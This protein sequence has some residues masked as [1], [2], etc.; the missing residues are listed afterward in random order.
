MKYYGIRQKILKAVESH[1]LF[2]RGDTLIIGFSGGADSTALL[3]LLHDL[4]GYELKLIAA[5]L[6]HSLRGK[7]SDLDELF[8][9]QTAQKLG[10][11]FESSCTDVKKRAEERGLNLEDAGRQ[12]RRDFFEKISKKYNANTIVLAQHADDQAE[13]VLMRLL[14]GSGATGLSG[15]EYRNQYGYI[16]PLLDISRKEIVSWLVNEGIPWREDESNNDTAFLRNRIRHELLPLLETYNPNIRQ[17]LLTTA[18]ILAAED[19]LLHSK[20]RLAVDSLFRTS[21]DGMQCNVKELL[22][23]PLPM[24]RRIIRHAY[25]QTAE[26]LHGFGW[27]HLKNCLQ[28]CHSGH[29]N[30]FISLPNNVHFRKTYDH[31]CISQTTTELPLQEERIIEGPGMYNLWDG[32]TV[33]IT[34]ETACHTIKPLSNRLNIN[35]ETIQF[36]WNVRTVRAGDR[37]QPYGMTGHAKVKDI[38]INAKIPAQNRK[39]IP[40][41]FCNN[42]LFWV[43]GVRYSSKCAITPETKRY[44]T[45]TLN[46]SNIGEV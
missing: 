34:E 38:F 35:P 37:I 21:A 26:T 5:H 45:I 43:S 17:T 13:T 27:K 39:R 42:V 46:Q 12:F 14:R 28:L 8:C 11:L 3:H 9:R 29:P 25:E 44:Y 18:E 31:L 2:N 33:T 7:A 16:R 32:I 23:Y 6:N 20:T 19:T 41:F 36:P 1:K 30:T 10:I 24:I 15:M 40:L 22:S 4:P